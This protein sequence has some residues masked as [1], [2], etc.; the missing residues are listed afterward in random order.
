MSLEAR[1]NNVKLITTVEFVE[2]LSALFDLGTQQAEKLTLA[3]SFTTKQDRYTLLDSGEGGTLIDALVGVSVFPN[4]TQSETARQLVREFLAYAQQLVSWVQASLVHEAINQEDLNITFSQLFGTPQLMFLISAL[5]EFDLLED[6]SPLKQLPV[7]V[8]ELIRHDFDPI[9]TCK[10]LLRTRIQDR[11]GSCIPVGIGFLKHIN[12]LDPRSSTRPST[13]RRELKELNKELANSLKDGDRQALI[14]ELTGIYAAMMALNHLHRR[15]YE[16]QPQYFAS[17]LRQLQEDFYAADALIAPPRRLVANH[18][19]FSFMLNTRNLKRLTATI[20]NTHSFTTLL[21]NHASFSSKGLPN[22]LRDFLREGMTRS[23]KRTRLLKVKEQLDRFSGKLYF[24]GV[25]LFIS[26]LLAISEQDFGAQT[27]FEKCL[28]AAGSWPLGPFRNQAALFL[29][30]LKLAQEPSQSPNA[31]NP[32]LSEYLDSLPQYFK[33][34]RTEDGQESVEMYNLRELIG[35]YNSLSWTLI[36]HTNAL[37]VNPFRKI[38]AYLQRIF[39][40]LH[41]SELTLTAK[42]LAAISDKLTTKRDIERVKSDI[43]GTPLNQWLTRKYLDEILR[44]LPYPDMWEM[45]PAIKRYLDLP[46]VMKDAIGRA[47]AISPTS[48]VSQ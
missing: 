27:H 30:G 37:M 31:W 11:L 29:L 28:D 1:N 3:K 17:V 36:G 8:D 26:G 16:R 12:S 9:K 5:L 15:T 2:A 4:G 40:G 25:T 7:C 45:V 19:L 32:L 44:A 48:E 46:E 24:D 20:S 43:F 33:I 47:S 35:Q 42:N 10:V 34:Q 23:W 18:G 39:D 22:S 21:E 41:E 6:C 14:D 13:Q 38:E